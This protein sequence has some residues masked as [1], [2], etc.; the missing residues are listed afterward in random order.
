MRKGGKTVTWTLYFDGA[1]EPKNPGGHAT[2]GWCL[3]TEEKEICAT[4]NGYICSGKGATNNLAEFTALA[5]ALQYI[6][7]NSMVKGSLICLGDSK[8]VTMTVSKKWKLKAPHLVIIRKRIWKLLAEM[9]CD[10]SISWI[11]RHLNS[12]ADELSKSVV[13]P[14]NTKESHAEKR[15][16]TFHI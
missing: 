15:K 2:Y 4:G 5:E 12:V 8:L 11:P 9:K 7:D 16:G 6:S 3:Y 14:V 13:I 10:W 1:C